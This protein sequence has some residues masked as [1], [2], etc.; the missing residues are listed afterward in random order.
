[1]MMQTPFNSSVPS[2]FLDCSGI[3]GGE[4][5]FQFFSF[6]VCLFVGLFVWFDSAFLIPECSGA[7]GWTLRNSFIFHIALLLF[8]HLLFRFMDWIQLTAPLILNAFIRSGPLALSHV[9]CVQ[10][11]GPV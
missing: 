6:L 8:E 4:L 7:H 1:V 11:I 3:I 9:K 2:G 10:F 5:L